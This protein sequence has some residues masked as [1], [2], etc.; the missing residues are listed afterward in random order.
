MDEIEFMNALDQYKRSSGRMFPTCSEI[1]EVLIKLGYKKAPEAGLSPEA[2]T[3]NETNTSE[4]APL[5]PVGDAGLE[6]HS[7]FAEICV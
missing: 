1:L 3:T 2:G 5:S 6:G 4:S 7:D